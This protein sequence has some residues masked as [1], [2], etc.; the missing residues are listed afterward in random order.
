MQCIT[1]PSS[2]RSVIYDRPKT[3]K[4]ACL[5]FF[6]VGQVFDPVPITFKHANFAEYYDLGR[7]VP[8]DAAENIRVITHV[9]WRR[10]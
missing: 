6:S 8:K 7:V 4:K 5:V 10:N 9:R 3:G 1:F 2:P